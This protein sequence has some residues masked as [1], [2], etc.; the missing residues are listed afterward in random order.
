M[1]TAGVLAGCP[2][3]VSAPGCGGGTAALSQLRATS[4]IALMARSSCSRVCAAL[5]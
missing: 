4:T 2:G 5:I 1:R 3:A